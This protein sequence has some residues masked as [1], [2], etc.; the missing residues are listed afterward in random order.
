MSKRHLAD[1]AILGGTPEFAETIHVGRPNIG[2]KA[3]LMERFA[4]VIDSGRL[5]NAGPQVQEFERRICEM[6]GVRHCVSVCNATVGLELLI[7][8]LG[9]TGEVIVPSLTFIATAHALQWQEITPVFCDVGRD[10]YLIDTAAVEKMITPRTTGIIGVHLWGRPCDVEALQDIAD[11]HRLKLMFDAAHAYG[12]SYRGR[13]VGSFGAAEVFSFHA[14]KFVNSFE[15]GAITTNDDELAAR[16]RLMRN[17]GFSD[18]DKVI[19]IGTNGKLPEISAAMGILSL[20]SIDAFVAANRRNYDIYT[21]ELSALPGVRVMA[22]DRAQRNNFQYVV[23]EIDAEA[24]GLSR[25]AVMRALHVENVL[26][27]RYFY[28][29]CHRMEPYRSHFPHAGLLLGNTEDILE[30]VL[31]LPTGT[32]MSADDVRR[33]CALLRLMLTADAADKRALADRCSTAG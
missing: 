18:Y 1:L 5:T 12:V 28:P 14:T 8:A 19:Y 3:L 30:R 23:I 24:A 27:R 9:L 32:A 22:Y 25:D 10:D 15:G 31:T 29:G 2:D 16:L 6:V 17:F 11:R 26:A 4:A 7:R 20:D 13:S 21:A 33:V